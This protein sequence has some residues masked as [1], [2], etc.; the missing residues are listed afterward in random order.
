MSILRLAW[1]TGKM[2]GSESSPLPF[3]PFFPFPLAPLPP[4]ASAFPFSL[5]AKSSQN[6]ADKME[7][8]ACVVTEYNTTCG[9]LCTP[10]QQPPPPTP[11]GKFMPGN[12]KT[13]SPAHKRTQWVPYSIRHV[14]IHSDIGTKTMK[15][16][17]RNVCF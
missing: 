8:H 1:I 3:F 13:L 4:F 10:G 5:P 11:Q 6:T 15:I 2:F 17:V 12:V 14:F 16:A 7:V 9:N